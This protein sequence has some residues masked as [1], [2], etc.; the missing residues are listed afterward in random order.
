MFGII[1][2]FLQIIPLLVTSNVLGKKLSIPELNDLKYKLYEDFDSISNRNSKYVNSTEEWNDIGAI[3][4]ITIGG[5]L[6]TEPYITPTLFKNA[7]DLAP[8]SNITIVDEWTLCQVL[9][10][11]TSKSLLGNH[12]ETWITEDDFK[13]ISDE[14]FNLVRIPIGYWAWKVN[15]TTDLYLKNSTYVDPYVGEGLQ[16]KYL[17]KALNWADKYGLKVWIDLHGAPGSQNGFDNSGERILY[18]DIGWLNNIATKTLTLSIWAELFKDYLNRSPVIGFEI[19]NEPLSSKIDINDIT[20]AY[21]EAFDSF[22]VQERNQNST[23]NTTFVI[24]DAFEPINYWNLQFNPQYANVSN[25][26]FNLTNITYSSSQIMVDHH[27]YEVFTDSQLAETQYERLLNIINYGNSIN[28]ELSYHGA[29]IGEWSGAITDCA[30]WLNGVDIGARYD[31]SYYN[32]TYFTSTSPPIGNCTSQN[33]ISTWTEDYRIKVRQ[34][35][36][37]QLATYSTKTSGWIFWNWKT[38][39]APEWD[40]LKLKSADLFPT[41]FDNFTYFQNNG[42]IDTIVS[43]SLSKEAYSSTHYKSTATKGGASN[44]GVS[45]KRFLKKDGIDR[46]FDTLLKNALFLLIGSILSICFFL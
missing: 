38:E 40:Y 13:Q 23:A 39:N 34:F 5:W 25:Q 4:G 11:N 21:Y 10:Y 32:T 18:G 35:I 29:I 27:H 15:H 8:S 1:L 44:F 24:H 22:K 6:V 36:E 43:V 12:F 9:G 7:T 28:E 42:S 19:M 17:D 41:P 30:T 46:P 37:A 26:F 45:S 20:Q 31:G 2:H 14:G 33:D 3:K 16:L